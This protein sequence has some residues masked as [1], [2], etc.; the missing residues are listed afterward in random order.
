MKKTLF[1]LIC[2]IGAFSLF[3][4]ELTASDLINYF[5]TEISAI[6][7][8]ISKKNFKLIKKSSDNLDDKNSYTY[9]W[10]VNFDTKTEDAFEWF[11]VSVYDEKKSRIM[12]ETKS[13]ANYL[14]FK[15]GLKKSGFK[16]SQ[17]F[18]NPEEIEPSAIYENDKFILTI[19]PRFDRW[20]IYLRKK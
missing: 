7:P 5:K 18:K 14:T 9:F 10:A 4:Q 20:T 8:S 15:Q 11:T 19:Q 16:F 6:S 2:L 1:T 17:N 3:A 13:K 12:Y